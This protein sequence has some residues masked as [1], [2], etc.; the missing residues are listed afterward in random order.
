MC[1]GRVSDVERERFVPG[2]FLL[3]P[4]SLSRR[5]NDNQVGF[6][7]ASLPTPFAGSYR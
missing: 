5:P 4:C 7:S 1:D 6:A 3:L 2:G